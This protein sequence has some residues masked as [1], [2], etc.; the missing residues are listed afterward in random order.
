MSE[1]PAETTRDGWPIAEACI[2]QGIRVRAPTKG[3]SMR[4]FLFGSDLLEIEPIA[5]AQLTV[6]DIVLVRT[7]AQEMLA[8]R[9]I[10]ITGDGENR[11]FDLKGDANLRIDRQVAPA[12][13]LGIVV[14]AIRD[15]RR[16]PLDRGWRRVA[17]RLWAW[18]TPVRPSTYPL[19]RR[20]WR[21]LKWLIHA[22][23][24]PPTRRKRRWE[25]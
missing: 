4:P 10:R 5:P 9:I 13:V 11:R 6:G 19:I 7:S 22:L 1:R 25:V 16:I 3:W 12:D 21:P 20:A 2:R 17:G 23:S 18:L 8:H 24:S 14:A 15:G